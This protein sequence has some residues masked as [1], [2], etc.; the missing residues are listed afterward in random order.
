LSQGINLNQDLG[1]LRIGAAVPSLRIADVDFNVKSIIELIKQARAEGVQAL[2]FPEMALTGYTLADLVQHQALL[3]KAEKGLAPILAESSGNP[4][5]IIFGMPLLVEQKIYNTAVIINNGR[6]L[7]VIPK[8]YLPNYKEFYDARWFES[9][10][11]NHTSVIELVDQVVPFGA[12]ILFK[13]KGFSSACVGVEI[14]EDLWVPFAP[15]E[16]QSVAGAN[17][18]FNLSASNE[19]L[20]KA[21]WRRTLVTSESGRCLAAYCYVSSSLGESSNDMIFGGHAII[22]EDGLILKESQRMQKEPQLIVSDIDL[23]RLAFDRRSG[24]T[25]Q[26]ST[27]NS[28][29]YR[30]IESE[31]KDIVP[32]ALS[33]QIDPH[34]FVPA[35]LSLRTHRCGVIFSMQVGALSKKLS[36][37]K[38]KNIVLGISGGLDSTLALLVA[39]RAM[40]FLGLPHTN[41]HCFT[42]PGFGTTSRTKNNATKL[43]KALGVSFEEVDITHT[44]SSQFEDLGHKGD[45]DIV[46]ENVQARYRTAFLFNKANELDAIN[47]GTGDLTEIA[48]GWSTFAGDQISHYHINV[49]V[50]KTL[51]R[52]LIRWVADEELAKSPAQAFLFDILDTPISPELLRP[53]K[54]KIAQ[55]SEDII[56]PVELADFYLYPFIRFGMRPGKI[57]FLANEARKQGLFDGKYTLEDLNKWLRSFISRFFANQ[58][59]RTCMPEGPKIGS[60]S[61]SPR[62]D[63]RMPSD[64]EPALWLEDLEAMYKKL[65]KK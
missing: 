43:C 5:L 61:L 7:G 18:L 19:V 62:S 60:V 24:G 64:A 25:F 6:I 14:C 38:K 46:F 52:F 21:D 42:L 3:Q 28:H 13:F 8:T 1:Y 54:G 47:L 36:G 10:L 45:E 55:K 57:L 16:Y 4:M 17:I 40:D 44:C 33:R 34:P 35:D 59:K 27:R 12:D 32:A 65:K 63:W 58:F 22:A 2:C 37:A 48:L 53:R 31:I 15:H 29:P 50:P 26:D 23:D 39:V 20:G 49:S 41:V 9:A 11:D 30:I 51:V 56:G